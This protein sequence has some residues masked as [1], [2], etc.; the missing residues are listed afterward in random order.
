[1]DDILSQDE[2]DQL[3]DAISDGA[4]AVVITKG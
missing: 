1:M 2:I 3:L 4:G